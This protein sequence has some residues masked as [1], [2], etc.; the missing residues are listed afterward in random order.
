MTGKLDMTHVFLLLTSLQ[1]VSPEILL[2]PQGERKETR[3]LLLISVLEL[4]EADERDWSESC[5]TCIFNEE[6]DLEQ[7]ATVM[8]R[9]ARMFN[10]YPA[11]T[12]ILGSADPKQSDLENKGNS[13]LVFINPRQVFITK[14]DFRIINVTFLPASLRNHLSS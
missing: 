4:G 10:Q 7:A 14:C 1:Q 6:E 12:I 11:F 5:S 2:E 9:V 8:E 3:G 13:P